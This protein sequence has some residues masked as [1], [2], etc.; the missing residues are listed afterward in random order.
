MNGVNISAFGLIYVFCSICG[1]K[2]VNV[3]SFWVLR[4]L[5]LLHNMFKC[6]Q[7]RN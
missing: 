6:V 5:F 4:K 3:H 7:M 1:L 2:P